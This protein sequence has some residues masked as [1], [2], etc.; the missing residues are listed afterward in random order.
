LDDMLRE[1]KPTGKIVEYLVIQT[2]T[3]QRTIDRDIT[4]L[5]GWINGAY[6]DGAFWAPGDDYVA[7][8]RPWYMETVAD[9]SEVAFVRPYLDEQSKTVMMTMGK[10]L[11]D[12]ES[13][14]AL[15]ISLS[16]IQ[17]IIEEIAAQTISS[18][19]IVLDKSGQVIAHT[20]AAERGKNYLEETGTFGAA[21]ADK[22]FRGEER[23]FELD[24]QGA[25]YVIYA[26]RIEGGWRCISLINTAEFFRPLQMILAVVLFL[27]VLE[28][29]VF[30]AVFYNLSA[31]NLA[32]SVQN[33]Q[34]GAVAD[35]Y[36]SIYDI[37]LAADTV[38]LIRRKGSGTQRLDEIEHGVQRVLDGLGLSRVDE[39]SRHVML[40]FLD[41]VSL[42]D[43]L[44]HT[45]TVTEEFLD[46]N[47]KWCRARFVA[48][49]RDEA[50][51]A[52]RVLL[53][54]ESIDEEKRR[55]DNLKLLSETDQMTGINN[56]TA[57]ERKIGALVNGGSGGMFVL[58]DIDKFKNV[59][60]RFGHEVGDKVI[61]A[62]ADA[63]NNAFRST[64]V[65]MRLGGDEFVAYAP[66][67][68]TEENG[69]TILS[70][71]FRNIADAHIAE[72]GDYPVY[73]SVGA[74][75][76][77]YDELLPFAELYKR[78]DLCAYESKKTMGNAVTFYH[79]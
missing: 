52:V 54:A 61:I 26:D 73:V 21:L 56:R 35:M 4:G 65:I 8:E 77:Q 27:T 33:V 15:D 12:G 19:V 42:V 75:F 24:Y 32:I 20:D 66:D 44:R 9:D 39:S 48:A 43:R 53:M 22:V 13:V 28:A 25:E 69:G 18:H 57:G 68:L 7:T 30:L 40:A 17:E 37:D 64:D 41:A 59:N 46:A 60:D 29:V 45:Q 76:C 71:L 49:E 58:L 36:V 79:E 2:Q 62:V 50:G 5:Y 72:L 47:R 3:I 55:R 10:R 70:R 74:A 6:C 1:R 11:C 34:I 67:V 31:K 63:M 38:R 14:L 51:Q 16:R 78:A 23:E